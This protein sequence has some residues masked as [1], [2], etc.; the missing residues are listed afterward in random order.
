MAMVGNTLG[1]EIKTAVDA[2]SSNDKLDM[3]KVW[4]AVG[5]AIIIHI[6]TNG[7]VSTITTCPAGAG[8]G[9]GTI[10]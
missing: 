4:Q 1:S 8:T 3:E 9:I 2:L 6:Q 10:A 5:G 7:V